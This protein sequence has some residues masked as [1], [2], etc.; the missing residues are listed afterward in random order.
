[1]GTYMCR[2]VLVL[3]KGLRRKK[4]LTVALC[5]LEVMATAKLSIAWLTFK[6]MPQ[7]TYRAIAKTEK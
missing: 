6:D 7:H 3:K 5:K 1:M 4:D 2:A